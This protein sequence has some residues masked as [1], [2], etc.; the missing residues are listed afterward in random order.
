MDDLI[1]RAVA[2]DDLEM[3]LILLEKHRPHFEI[4]MSRGIRMHMAA[5]TIRLMQE[6]LGFQMRR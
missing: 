4:L 6:K 5:D 1:Q 2:Y 3:I